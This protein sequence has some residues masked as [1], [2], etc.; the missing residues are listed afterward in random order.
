LFVLLLGTI[1]IPPIVTI[2][3]TYLLFGVFGWLNTHWSLMIPPFL[4]GALGTF[5]LRQYFITIPQDLV[6]AAKIDGC[7]DFGIY[8]RIFLPLSKP[9]LAAFAVL[10]FNYHWNDVLAPVIYLSDRKLYTIAVGLYL[11]KGYQLTRWNLLMAGSVMAVV[12]V[13]AVYILLQKYF[14][15]GIATTGLKG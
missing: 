3:P 6:D 4:G 15:E 11:L 13:L 9:A 14:I 1:M 10:V 7:S 2:V 12:P 8:W 5:L